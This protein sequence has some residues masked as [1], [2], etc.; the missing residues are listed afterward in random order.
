MGSGKGKARRAQSAKFIGTSLSAEEAL[1]FY[2]HNKVPA[3][4]ATGEPIPADTSLT[5]VQQIY[6]YS[7][8]RQRTLKDVWSTPAESVMDLTAKDIPWYTVSVASEIDPASFPESIGGVPIILLPT[9]PP[10]RLGSAPLASDETTDK[11]GGKGLDA[12][13][14]GKNT[15]E[16]V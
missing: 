6:D 11:L 3:Q 10:Q 9:G 2:V 14:E 12:K 15:Q 5:A 7:S 8:E 13:L 1:Q 4:L 16:A